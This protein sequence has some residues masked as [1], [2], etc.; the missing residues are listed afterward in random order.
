MRVGIIGSTGNLGLQLLEVISAINENLIESPEEIQIVGLATNK[1]IELL[2]EQVIKY[3]PE[4]VLVFDEEAY[5]EFLSKTSTEILG[6]V[7]ILTGLEGLKTFSTYE[8]IDTLVVL[9]TGYMGIVPIVEGIENGKR[10][11]TANKESIIIWGQ[12]IIPKYRNSHKFIPADSEHFT[13][14]QILRK[15][16]PNINDIHKVILTASGG[17]FW[18]MS[19]TEIED[20][21]IDDVL[22]HPR[23]NMGKY[24]TVGSANLFNKSLEILET[25]ALFDIPYEKIDVA[26]HPQA[27]VHA[28]IMYKNGMM[29]NII[30][31]TNMKIVLANALM[32]PKNIDMKN[33]FGSLEIYGI[34]EENLEF[35]PVDLERFPLIKWAYEVGKSG[36]MLPAVFTLAGEISI[37]YFLEGI[38]KFHQIEELI[39]KTLEKFSYLSSVKNFYI[40]EVNELQEKLKEYIFKV[41]VGG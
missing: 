18:K 35:Y 2:K 4:L 26:I 37:N 19:R 22:K 13:I 1:N 15:V 5:Q 11:I 30:H 41:V 10:V 6:N 33:S 27:K 20:V 17:P 40:D 12:T 9:L 7:K 31:Q 36:G 38:I 39:L 8:N 24:I 28:F 3:K 34:L 16:N 14:F 23:W 21:K 29:W 32:Y 25:N